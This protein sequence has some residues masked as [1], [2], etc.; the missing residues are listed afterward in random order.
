MRILDL[1]CGAGGFSLGFKQVFKDAEII[2]V[3]L[4]R[5]ACRTYQFNRV[6]QAI[7]ADVRYLPIRPEPGLF[8]IIIG[9]P[10]C[11]PFSKLNRRR[12]GKDHPLYDLTLWFIYWC[13]VFQPKVWVMENVPELMD[14]PFYGPLIRRLCEPGTQQTLDAYLNRSCGGVV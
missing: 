8:D 7:R 5:D 10:P 3:D 9:G 4:S 1:F 2:G 14:D 12:R 6:G 13:I 11:E